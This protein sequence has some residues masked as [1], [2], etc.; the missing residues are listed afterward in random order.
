MIGCVREIPQATHKLSST[1]LEQL[2]RSQ[3]IISG[4]GNHI[5]TDRGIRQAHL[6]IGRELVEPL[7]LISDLGGSLKIQ[8]FCIAIH[9]RMEQRLQFITAPL[10]H[11]RHLAQ[12]A[13]VIIRGDFF[14]TY[15]WTT[16]DA[17]IQAGSVGMQ[18]AGTLPQRKDPLH[19]EE[20]SPEQSHIHVRAVK[21]IE[22]ATEAAPTRNKNAWISFAPGDAEIGI[23]LVIF[24]QHIE[25]GLLVLDQIRLERECF[26]LAVGDDELNVTNLTHHQTD[27]RA[28]VV[29]AAEIAAH[30]T[31]QAF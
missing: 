2:H 22:G 25:V 1:H 17:V 7:Q 15:A 21:T 5:T 3:T 12:G 30:T 23:F 31:A 28:E 14:L 10:K 26:G 4:H 8:P 24:K 13:V 27:A 20:S 6:L 18:R 9:L 16:S 11:H 29:S 19:K